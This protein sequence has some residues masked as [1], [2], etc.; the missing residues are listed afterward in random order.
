MITRG[1]HEILF[2]TEV[3]LCRAERGMA[4]REPDLLQSG[5]ALLRQLRM[6]AAQVMRSQSN[7]ERHRV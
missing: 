2:K 3:H 4:E 6:R 5:P 1:I 7:V